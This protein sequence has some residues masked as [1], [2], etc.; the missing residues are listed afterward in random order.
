MDLVNLMEDY[1]GFVHPW[2][3]LIMNLMGK[4]EREVDAI[5]DALYE[6]TKDMTATYRVFP[7]DLRTSPEGLW[8]LELQL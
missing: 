5:R 8:L 2:R 3:L 7:C 1:K 4:V 6:K